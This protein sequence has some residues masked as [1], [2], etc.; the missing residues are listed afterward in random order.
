MTK[1]EFV[2][3]FADYCEFEDQNLTLDT[4]LKSIEG[5]D[6]IAIMSM[7]AFLDENFKIKININQ[8]QDL[9]DFNSLIGLIGEEKFDR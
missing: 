6:S 7:I 3:K 9:K 8:I 1:N 5:Y 2:V 4:P